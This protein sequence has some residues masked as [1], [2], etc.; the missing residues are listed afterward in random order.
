[1]P[2][3]RIL[4]LIFRPITKD[5]DEI[6]QLNKVILKHQ[7]Y[8]SLSPHQKTKFI[9]ENSE[10]ANKYLDHDQI[11]DIIIRTNSYNVLQ[12]LREI[13]KGSNWNGKQE[14]LDRATKK[15]MNI[16][17][18]RLLREFLDSLREKG[19]SIDYIELFK[20]LA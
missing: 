6:R 16:E 19:T 20:E 14:M 7:E 13:I 11:M 9:V 8:A 17:D 4:K 12:R 3:G 1:L 15:M 10:Y 18:K 2:V 5:F